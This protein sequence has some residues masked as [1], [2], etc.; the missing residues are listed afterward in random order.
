MNDILFL[1]DYLN[2]LIILDISFQ[3]NLLMY[4]LI[5]YDFMV[6]IQKKMN[7]MNLIIN[8]LLIYLFHLLFL[9]LII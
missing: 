9:I 8:V 5:F 1:N 7:F 4:V 3:K 2:L 6:Y